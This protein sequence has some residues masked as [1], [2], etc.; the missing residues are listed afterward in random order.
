MR[1][2]VLARCS[3]GT[4][5]L[6]ALL[7]ACGG[8]DRSRTDAL[9]QAPV[10]PD[11]GSGPFSCSEAATSSVFVWEDFEF[12]AASGWYTNNEVCSPCQELWDNSKYVQQSLDWLQGIVDLDSA[13]LEDWVRGIMMKKTD[14][15]ES[16]AVFGRI[17]ADLKGCALADEGDNPCQSLMEALDLLI[18]ALPE[19]EDVDSPSDDELSDLVEGLDEVAETATKVKEAV[20]AFDTER[21]SCFASCNASQEPSAFDK[22]LPAERIPGGRC[23]SQYALR[24][25]SQNLSD[26]GGVVGLQFASYDA[27]D[28]DGVSFWARVGPG[29]PHHI[30]V[31]FSDRHTDDEYVDPDTRERPCLANTTDD[32]AREGCD[33]FGSSVQLSTDWQFVTLPFVEM[34]QAGWGKRSPE[35]ETWALLSIGINYTVGSWDL[36]IDDIGF[37]RRADN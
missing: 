21:T 37:Y 14:L 1:R 10:V 33:K 30:R 9:Y 28:Y 19:P 15:A 22:P 12:G 4:S 25:A 8:E 2:A 31:Q 6:F 17:Q 20:A 11:P 29:S 35:L 13:D 5:L 26:W 16:R 24:I 32:N 27:S 23:A 7:G 3:W 18:R 36:W 34:R